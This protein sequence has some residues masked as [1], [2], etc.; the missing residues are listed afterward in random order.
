MMKYGEKKSHLRKKQTGRQEV[1]PGHSGLLTC[2]LAID[3]CCLR[4][5]W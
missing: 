4:R 1:V 2:S 3:S 5:H